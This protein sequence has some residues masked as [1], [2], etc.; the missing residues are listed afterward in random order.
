MS[1]PYDPE[2]R[3]AEAAEAS[4]LHEGEKVRRK[5]EGITA[6]WPWTIKEI[7]WQ[8]MLTFGTNSIRLH[9]KDTI[10]FYRLWRL[11]TSPVGYCEV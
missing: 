9:N 4:I 10:T 1:V 8:S 11:Y 6:T 7:S 3:R 2:K 5:E